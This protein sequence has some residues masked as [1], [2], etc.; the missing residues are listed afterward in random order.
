MELASGIAAR[1]KTVIPH[2]AVSV[3][4]ANREFEAWFLASAESLSGR[5]GLLVAEGESPSDPDAIRGAKEW[6]SGRIANGRY[7]ETTDQ[8]AFSALID[9]EV[10]RRRSRSFR[11]LCT[12]WS[13]FAVAGQ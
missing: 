7:R 11:K 13:H 2:C 5:R 12:D 10:A 9:L 8:P 3:V 4:C 6:L 1:A